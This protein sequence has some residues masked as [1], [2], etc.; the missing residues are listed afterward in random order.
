LKE[1][2]FSELES[3]TGGTV[4][5]AG[6]DRIIQHLC[7][8]SRKAVTSESAL[9]FAVAGERHNGHTFLAELYDRGLRQFVVER[10]PGVQLPGANVLLV[11]NSVEALQKLAAY[12]RARFSIPVIAVTGSNG[13]TVVKEWIFQLLQEKKLITKNPGSYNSQTG[14]PLSVWQLHAATEVAVFEA[15]ISKPGEMENLHRVIRPTIGVFT[16]LG[17]AHDEGFADREEKAGEKLRLFND[18]EAVVYCRDQEAVDRIMTAS[19]PNRWTWGRKD[20]TDVQI[21]D[22]EA[23]AL[24]IRCRHQDITLSPP[25]SDTASLENMMHAVATLLYMG[26]E[27][28]EIAGG[29]RHLRPISMR[30]QVRQGINHCLVIDDSYNNDLAGLRLGLDFLEGQLHAKKSLILSE[31]LQTGLSQDRVARTVAEWTKQHRLSHIELVGATWRDHLAAFEIP[32]RVFDSVD[33]YLSVFDPERYQSEAILVKGARPFQ[34][35]RIVRRLERKVH[36]TVMEI[37]QGALIANLNFFRSR[38]YAGTKVMVMVKAFAYGSGSLEVASLLQ[39]HRVDFLGVAY[40]DEGIQLRKHGIHLPILVMNTSEDAY[41]QLLEYRLEPEVYSIEQLQSLALFLDGRTCRVHLK[42]DTGMHRLGLDESDIDGAIG[43]LEANKNLVVASV[44]SH[45][46]GA[47]AADLDAFSAD[48]AVSFGRMCDKISAGLG[49]MPMRHLLNSAGILR[50]PEYQFEMVRLGIGLFGIDPTS[51]QSY[52]LRPVTTLKTIVSQVRRV[53]S[54][55]SVGYGRK[56][57]AMGD[58]EVATIAIGYA[59][60]YSRAFSQGK[61]VVAIL[62]QRVPVIG[63]VCMDMTMVEVTGMGVKAGDEVIVYGPPLPI[64]EVA[65]RIGTI[66]YEILTSTSDRVKRVFYAESL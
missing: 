40:P 27:P 60:G 47:D 37:D 66:P 14:V 17:P 9:F 12:H 8:D 6:A 26:V 24:K 50:L 29:V 45:L 31:I 22:E 58:I 59:D 54:G 1:I 48:Q 3:I 57:R 46:A 2:L 25:F 7:L 11:R 16:N 55:D 13:K 34:F 21:V 39:Y 35:E 49:F 32:V 5:Q 20:G 4:L 28:A 19:I 53:K 10:W 43:I 65:E 61:G 15:G 64:R 36:G 44:F 41:P 56:G 38:L 42:F 23:G 33:D 18:C 30:M 62:G 51:S 52:P 63:N